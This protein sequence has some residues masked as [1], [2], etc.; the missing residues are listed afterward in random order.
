MAT[1]QNLVTGNRKTS[2]G[3][4]PTTRDGKH[5]YATAVSNLALHTYSPFIVQPPRPTLPTPYIYFNDWRPKCNN[6]RNRL[7]MK[8]LIYKLADGNVGGL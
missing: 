3:A 7:V 1:K 2:S 8:T 4:K 6:I 5:Q